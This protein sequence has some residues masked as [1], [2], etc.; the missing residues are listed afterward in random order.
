MIKP[1]QIPNEVCAAAIRHWMNGEK[2]YGEQQT[3][4][5]VIAAALNAWPGAFPWTFNGPLDGTGYVLP[6][7]GGD[8]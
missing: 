3:M 8:A 1:N 7:E 6:V 5:E 4:A 2:L